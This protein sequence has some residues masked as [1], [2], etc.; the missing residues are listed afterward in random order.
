MFLS[1]KSLG[2]RST[3]RWILLAFYAALMMLTLAAPAL[4]QAQEGGQIEVLRVEGAITPVVVEYVERAI[5]AAEANGANLLIITL[6]T[7][8]GSVEVTR[9]LTSRMTAARVPIVVYVAP[10]GAH[11]ASAGTFV[12]LAAHVAAM[13]PGTSIGAASPIASGGEEM[14]ETAKE[15]AISILEADVAGLAR[16]RGEEAV[17][18]A[19]KAVREAKA[20]TEEEA[21]ELGVID[22]I[23]TDL[24][25]L[26][27]QLDGRQVE[28]A[29]TEVVLETRGASLHEAEMDPV[30]RFLHVIT[31]PNIAFILVTLG[32]NGLL[33]E[34]SS[35][36]GWV[37]GVVGAICL[38]LGLYGL[39]V[40]EANWIGLFLIVVAFVLFVLD[41][42]APTHG[43]LTL[44][45]LVSFVFGSMLLFD[46]PYYEISRPLVFGVALATAGF[47]A[48]AVAKAIRAQTRQPTTGLEGMVG[49]TADARTD[50]DPEGSVFLMGEWW[51]A[52][53]EDGPIPKGETVVVVGYEGFR[54][55]V[56]RQGD[57]PPPSTPNG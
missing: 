42:K 20:A 25:D 18:W 45:G 24:D 5:E 56:R 57:A 32:M 23:A 15:K 11:A 54:L 50:L 8:G 26:L 22:L 7:P 38:L 37:A 41:I 2:R 49:R 52:L 21:L 34:L 35:P 48:F 44:G 29:G 43:V 46:S 30:E 6:D 4:S 47:F 31:D 1:E 14:G 10:T 13:A 33:F 3:P 40:L 16:R 53:A 19:R 12:T 51:E 39:G 9:R 27:E 55:R 17:E 36:G 28:V